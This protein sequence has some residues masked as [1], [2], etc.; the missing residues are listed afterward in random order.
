MGLLTKN[1]GEISQFHQGAG[2]DTMI[3]LFKLLQEIPTQSLLVID[4]VE[5]SLHPQAQRRLVRY[6]LK[7]ARTK[8]LQIILSTHSPFVLEEL[9]LQAR[10]MLV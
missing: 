5:N 8:K 4:E 7:L 9:P 6:L 10:I 2:E 1:Y 3:D